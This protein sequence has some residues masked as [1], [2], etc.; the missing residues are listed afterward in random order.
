M[1]INYWV[2]PTIKSTKIV[3]DLA[4]ILQ[5]KGYNTDIYIS[6][7]QTHSYGTV[8]SIGNMAGS[9]PEVLVQYFSSRGVPSNLRFEVTWK[10]WKTVT[11]D[12][13]TITKE[14]MTNL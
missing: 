6:K 1:E 9:D 5:E 14:L 3:K 4:K 2:R 13:R 11:G 12:Y 7:Q 10:N 8:W